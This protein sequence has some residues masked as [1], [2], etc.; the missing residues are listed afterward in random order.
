ME[1]VSIIRG[2]LPILVIAPHGHDDSNTDYLAEQ[3]AKELNCYA[4][5]NRGWMRAPE[6][7]YWN[8]LANCNDVRHC[9]EDVVKEEFLDPILRFANRIEKDYGF[10]A[11]FNIHGMSNEVKKIAKNLDIVVGYGAG[12][13]PSYS[14]DPRL[15]DAF[16]YL[17]EES[18]LGAYEGAGGGQYAGRAKNNLNQLFRRWYPQQRIQSLQVEIVGELRADLEVSKVTAQVLAEC[19]NDFLDY[20]DSKLR[21]LLVIPKTF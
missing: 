7:D 13:P 14:C 10:G 12:K 20:D 11:V 4:V 1:R 6:V 16:I 8:D 18:G 17:L 9:H 21:D 19:M 3:I 5:I 2:D 15:K